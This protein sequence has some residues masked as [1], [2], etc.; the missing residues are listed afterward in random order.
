MDY[1]VPWLRRK[2]AQLREGCRYEMNDPEPTEQD[3]VAAEQRRSSDVELA[4]ILAAANLLILL[5]CW[6]IQGV[7]ADE[8]TYIYGALEMLKG[9]S[10]YRDFWVFYP[11]GIFFLAVGAF[12]VLGKT[13]FSVRLIMILGACATTAVLYLLGRRFMS[14]FPSAAAA[15]LFMTAGVN[16]WPVF[17][18]HW[19]STFALVVSAYFMTRFLEQSQNRFLAWSGLFAGVTL[20]LQLHKGIPLVAGVLLIVFA[21][22]VMTGE[23]GSHRFKGSLRTGLMFLFWTMI[24]VGMAVLYLAACGVLREAAG[25]VILFPFRQ[26][27]GV[28][29]PDYGVPYAAYSVGV[30]STLMKF[31]EVPGITTTCVHAVAI[32]ITVAA[33]LSAVLVPVVLLQRRRR[34]GMESVQVPFFAAIAALGCLIASVGRPDF[35]HLVTAAPMGYLTLAFLAFSKSPFDNG[36]VQFKL[37]NVPRRI[38]FAGLLAASVWIGA[39]TLLYGVHVKTLYLDSPLGFVALASEE[40]S[41]PMVSTPYE[42]LISFIKVN[43][44]PDEK[45][46]VMPSSP[47]LYY[48]T[49]REN[50]TRYTMLMSSLRD[51]EQMSEIIAA[52][53]QDR[54]RWVILDP[55]ASW[56]QYKAAL[57]YADEEEFRRNP[58]LRYIRTNYRK[59]VDYSG[60]ELMERAEEASSR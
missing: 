51:H 10:I 54:T 13:L 3:A 52:L 1:N 47:F 34:L 17:G 53:E 49:G 8:S 6:K 2:Q 28:G 44:A 18:H 20:L 43:T 29:N 45:I 46:F 38:V 35:H 55:A 19:N 4:L 12:A 33:P 22:A 31:L 7:Q 42:S 37:L 21:S 32:M 15:T 41:E 26:L 25:A 24:P 11:P 56:R 30:I 23:S 50:A 60:F 27:T 57:P 14:R 59:T 16:L 5:V 9:K 48:L 58:L 39:G 36:S 40:E